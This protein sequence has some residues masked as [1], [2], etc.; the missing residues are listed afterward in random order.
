MIETPRGP[1]AIRPTRE[2]DAVAYREL[3]LEALR[4]HPEAFGADY[5]ES[6]ARPIER[7]Q[8][9]VRDGAGTDLGI[10]YVAEVAGGLVGMT[11][12]YRDSGAKMRH[13]GIIWGV[14]VRAD[15]RG[16]GIAEALIDACVRWAEIQGLRLVTLSVVTTNAA[17]IRC[18][19]R[20][21][22]SV[23]GM[24]PEVIYHNGVYYDE[25]LMVRRL[26]P[27]DKGAIL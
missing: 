8:Q 3:R 15:W 11:G 26:D 24:D 6:L 21:G 7:W 23:Y 14:Y 22:F 10:T 9:N 2:D 19:V 25:L 16:A 13:R 17:A 20:C 12:I 5:E 18:Y 4:T 27:V 1:I